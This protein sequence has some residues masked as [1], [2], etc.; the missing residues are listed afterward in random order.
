M[1]TLPRPVSLVCSIRSAPANSNNTA[2]IVHRI[3][4]RQRLTR[5]LALRRNEIENANRRKSLEEEVRIAA[6]DDAA[7]AAATPWGSSP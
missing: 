6:L 4:C 5:L 7:P 3:E 1:A 2:M